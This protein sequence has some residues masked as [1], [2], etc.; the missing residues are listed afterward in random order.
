MGQIV[1]TYEGSALSNDSMEINFPELKYDKKEAFQRETKQF[2]CLRRIPEMSKLTDAVIASWYLEPVSISSRKWHR[3][4][5]QSPIGFAL[6]NDQSKQLEQTLH[7][8]RGRDLSVDGISFF[9]PEPI[10]SREVA[11]TFDLERPVMEFLVTRLAWSRFSEDHCFRSGGKFL[12]QIEAD[13][14]HFQICSK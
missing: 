9:H 13:A 8:V 14:S 10:Y 5:C 4:P 11:F 2:P 1:E 3:I 7:T 12:R 6:I